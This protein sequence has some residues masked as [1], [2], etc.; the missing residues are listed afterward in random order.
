MSPLSPL[1]A[2]T[3]WFAGLLNNQLVAEVSYL[4]DTVILRNHDG[5]PIESIPVAVIHTLTLTPKFFR[6]QLVIETKVGR[7]ISVKWLQRR[8]SQALHDAVQLRIAHHRQVEEERL[9]RQALHDAVELR[10]ARH[11][12]QVEEERLER[13]AAALA[14]DLTVQITVWV[15]RLKRLLPLNQ[16]IRQSRAVQANGLAR[17]LTGQFNERT[18]LHLDVEPSRALSW[19]EEVAELDTL[20]SLR[21]KSNRDFTDRTV[22]SV[23]NATDGL[24][25]NRLTDEQARAIATDEDVTLVLAGAG[26]GKTA[27]II[28]KIAHL[29][30]NLGVPPAAILALAFNRDAAIEIKN[31]L[32]ANLEGVNVST[33]HSFGLKVISSIDKAPS[34][35]KMAQDKYAFSKAIDNILHEMMMDAELAE[36]VIAL[37]ST[38]SAEYR[39]PFDFDSQVA[40]QQYISENELRT[41]SGDL[42]KSFE[43]LTLANFLTRN[44]IAFEYEKSYQFPTG[45]QKY[46][47]YRPDFYL[48]DY[49]IY[50]EHFALN[51][52]GRP[53]PGWTG[54]AVGVDWKRK[55]HHRHQ[56]RFIETYSWQRK[57]GTLLTTLEEILRSHKV[58]FSPVP[59][60]ELIRKLS[61][62]R[63]SWLSKLAGTFLHH[64]KSAD[65]R[66]EEIPTTG[67]K[68]AGTQGELSTSSLY[69][70][71]FFGN[72]RRCWRQNQSID[73]HD[74]INQATGIIR[75]GDWHNPYQYVLIDEFQDISDGRMA[76]AQ[77]LKQPELAYFLLA[78][79][80]N[81]S[82]GSPA[83][84]SG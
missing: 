42:V 36:P 27:V 80:G 10:M 31:R 40:Y 67:H 56:T 26:T 76:L 7:T 63:L 66:A 3:S 77:A 55:L 8:Q 19:I 16:Y 5:K 18:R 68:T 35:S 65:L 24:L 12:Q 23:Q 75:K 60:Q 29:V 61:Q 13:Q 17:Q 82:I 79:T 62:E 81:P 28:G 1:V 64:V 59:V 46:R 72:I 45:T 20:F 48:P 30:R 84:M 58:V 32:P 50:I 41:L 74:L 11:R 33:F 37:V 21:D 47:Q 54:Y 83:A 73:F 22:P 57:D 15:D 44:G 9:E 78:M 69:S 49:D 52:D 39:T 2:E 6:N 43:E 71:A 25:P 51:R 70:G 38:L 4:D 14:R 34:I 53:P